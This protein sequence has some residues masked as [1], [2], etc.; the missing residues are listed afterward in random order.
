MKLASDVNRGSAQIGLPL[1]GPLTPV[2]GDSLQ[3]L[4][5]EVCIKFSR[6]SWPYSIEGKMEGGTRVRARDPRPIEGRKV[7][8]REL[9]TR[10]WL[11]Q[12]LR[13]AKNDSK[14]ASVRAMT[15]VRVRLRS[16]RVSLTR[17]AVSSFPN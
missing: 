8:R 1:L 7:G 3:G 15:R 11:K 14:S 13:P 9:P 16:T 2:P 6:H 12:S 4:R 10:H 17:R 5:D